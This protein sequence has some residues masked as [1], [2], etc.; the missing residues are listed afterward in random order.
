MFVESPE[1]R[2][3]F[4]GVTKKNTEPPQTLRSMQRSTEDKQGNITMRKYI[5]QKYPLVF[6]LCLP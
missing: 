3:E 6:V 1:L 5:V 2:G 4:F